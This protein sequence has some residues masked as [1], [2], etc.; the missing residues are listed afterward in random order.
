MDGHQAD[1]A[2][3]AARHT[4]GERPAGPIWHFWV[5]RSGVPWRDLP[6][7]FGPHTTCYNRFVRTGVV[8]LTHLGRRAL[9]GSGCG[10][11]VTQGV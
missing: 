1:A 4:T 2:E 9:G 8:Q 3:Q 6:D 5:L 7:D 10:L 11:S